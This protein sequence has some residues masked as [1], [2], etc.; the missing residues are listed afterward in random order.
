[1]FNGSALNV[2]DLRV[3]IGIP[4]SIKDFATITP[5]AVTI[6][7][8]IYIDAGFIN[9]YNASTVAGLAG[10]A[11]EG[12]HSLQFAI[13]GEDKQKFNYL[14]ESLKKSLGGKNAYSDNEYEKEAYEVQGTMK[15]YIRK[16]YG[17]RPCQ[18]LGLSP[19]AK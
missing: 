12:W 5:A 18:T 15:D 17:D 13:A 11:H 8:T 4:Q 9:Q 10:L 19:K 3:R 16:I 2:D 7:N 1:L 14:W 6:S